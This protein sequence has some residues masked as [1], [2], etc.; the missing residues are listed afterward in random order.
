M[1]EPV[2]NRGR[3]WFE[4]LARNDGKV[5]GNPGSLMVS[6]ATLDGEKVVYVGIAS[7]PQARFP[8]TGH[9]EVGLEEGWYGTRAIRAA[10]EADRNGPKRPLIT[11]CD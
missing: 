4:A 10:I 3:L 7:D 1:T 6:E 2:I 5:A 9:T 11:I 8:R